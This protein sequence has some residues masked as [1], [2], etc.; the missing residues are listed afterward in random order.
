MIREF[1]GMPS[2]LPAASSVSGVVA[3]DTETSGLHPDDGA[4]V[5]VVSVAWHEGDDIVHA[6][7]PF[8]QGG[9]NDSPVY[10]I[11]RREWMELCRWLAFAGNGLVGH[12]LKFDLVMMWGGAKPGYEGINLLGRAR[13]DTMVLAKELWPTGALGLKPLSVKLF[14]EDADAEQQA[15]K[16]HLGPKTNPRF[17][18]VPWEVMKPYA[19]ADASLTLRLLD[20]QAELIEEGRWGS[21]MWSRELEITKALTRMEL[22]GIPYDPQLSRDLAKKL[23]EHQADILGKLPY[24][25]NKA[26]SYYFTD[27]GL[28]LKP[29]ARTEKGAPQMTADILERMG[30]DGIEW[31]AELLEYNRIKSALSKWYIPFADKT[32]PDGRLRTQFRQVANE[33]GDHGG[34]KSGRFSAGRVNLQAVPKDYALHLPVPTP[35]AV[36]RAAV[37]Q[38]E[39][40]SLFD[41]DLAQAELRVAALD[42]ECQKMLNLIVAGDDAHG[43]TATEL[44]GTKPGDEM[45]KV[46]R[47]IA[48]RANFSLIFGSG[49]KT[50]R[51]MVQKE[52][53]IDLGDAESKRIVY[54]WRDIYPEFGKA[55]D[56]EMA[57]VE[58]TGYVELYNGRRR[59]YLPNEDHHSAFNQR[60]QGS[61]AEMG[62]NWLLRTDR[63]LRPL[64]PRGR[65]E[66]GTLGGLLLVVHDSQVVLLPDEEAED[67]LAQVVAGGI[68]SWDELF[69]GVPGGV[70]ATP[71]E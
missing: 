2:E 69:P 58:R 57:F 19:M 63:L 60:V 33:R 70:D 12:N 21:K 22:A 9:K 17:D 8:G 44:F 41:L 6:A 46:H 16:P 66:I 47:Q 3:Y 52:A 40:W 55:I 43:S 34:T 27:A 39:G 20:R 62:K 31:T 35:R 54:G 29:Y 5:S 51:A 32:G 50:F 15:L 26:K 36:I 65:E 37:A 7:W 10:D 42:A 67:W 45:W 25:P 30:R 18:L 14:G 11:G 71:W 61:I 38:Y 56:R 13:F 64:R 23:E 4:R 28:N 1:E 59:Y 49:P 48:K 53:G 68:L 24:E